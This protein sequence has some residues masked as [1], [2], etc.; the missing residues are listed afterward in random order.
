MTF[1]SEHLSNEM[2][3]EEGSLYHTIINVLSKGEAK[4][5]GANRMQIF[6]EKTLRKIKENFNINS[7][8]SVMIL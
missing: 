6:L 7:E 8:K 1:L 3:M 5:H 2:L 4:L